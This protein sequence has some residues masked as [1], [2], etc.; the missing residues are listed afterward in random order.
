MFGMPEDP[1][2]SKP[3]IHEIGQDLS[4]LS[5]HELDERVEALR[6]EIERLEAAKAAKSD[7]RRA[8]EQAFRFRD[9]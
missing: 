8:A 3:A 6:A 1:P 2:R 4:T 9:A 5:L 7:S